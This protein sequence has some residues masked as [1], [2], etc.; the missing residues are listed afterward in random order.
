MSRTAINRGRD[1]LTG[2]TRIWMS[3]IERPVTGR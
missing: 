3:R 1:S 2:R